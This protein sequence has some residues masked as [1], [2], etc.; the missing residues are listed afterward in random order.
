M[1]SS[2]SVSTEVTTER[3]SQFTSKLFR[4]FSQLPSSNHI[5]IIAYHPTANEFVE[6]FQLQLKSLIIV[7]SSKPDW[8]KRLPVILFAFRTT[9]KKDLK[10]SLAEIVFGEMII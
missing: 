6:R 4:R 7:T 3:D 10:C 1:D 5:K 9:V 2:F 8:S